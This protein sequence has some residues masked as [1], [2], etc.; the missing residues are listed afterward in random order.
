[1]EPTTLLLKPVEASVTL[2]FDLDT[3]VCSAVA[4]ALQPEIKR[5]SERFVEAELKVSDDGHLKLLLKSEDLANLRAGANSY[6]NLIRA[7]SEALLSLN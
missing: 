7:S 4:E 3:R 5:G 1:V 6:F 2:E